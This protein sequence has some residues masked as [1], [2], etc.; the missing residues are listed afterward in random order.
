MGLEIVP[1]GEECPFQDAGPTPFAEAR[2]QIDAWEK[3]YPT[4]VRHIVVILDADE[5]VAF[6]ITGV[7]QRHASAGILAMVMNRVL[8]Q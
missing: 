2:A 8:N 6:T 4:K 3:A 7:M 5:D 1:A